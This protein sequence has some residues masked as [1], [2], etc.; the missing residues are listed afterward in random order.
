MK[1]GERRSKMEGLLKGSSMRAERKE[2]WSE[3][4]IR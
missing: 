3:E 2:G 1:A 4:D